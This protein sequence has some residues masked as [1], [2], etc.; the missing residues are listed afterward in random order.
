[1]TSNGRGRCASATSPWLMSSRVA[2]PMRNSS[3]C[4][5]RPNRAAAAAITRTSIARPP[6]EPTVFNQRIRLSSQ[7]VRSETMASPMTASNRSSGVASKCTQTHPATTTTRINAS[8]S[9]P[10]NPI[11]LGSGGAP[12]V[13]RLVR[14]VADGTLT[15]RSAACSRWSNPVPPRPD[16]RMINLGRI[17]AEWTSAC[18]MGL[19]GAGD[20]EAGDQEEEDLADRPDRLLRG[21]GRRDLLLRD[22]EAGGLLGGLAHDPPDDQPGDRQL[23]RR[24]DLQ[25]L[26]LLVAEHGIAPRAPT[27][28]GGRLQPDDHHGR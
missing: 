13:G 10:V 7:E 19:Y 21:P 3:R 14:W 9:A 16:P 8:Q 20:G 27:V 5:H 12:P 18:R 25:P 17:A 28:A 24:D 22:P 15:T 1:M 2:K 11:F 4:R 23:D 26:H 6:R